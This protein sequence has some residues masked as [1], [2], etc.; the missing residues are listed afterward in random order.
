M[1]AVKT[2]SYFL[3]RNLLQQSSQTRREIYLA[4]TVALVRSLIIK[5][6]DIANQIHY[7][8]TERYPELFYGMDNKLNYRY[9]NHLAGNYLSTDTEMFIYSLDSK[10]TIRLDKD[11]NGHALTYRKLVDD[12]TYYKTLVAKYPTQER[13]I[14]GMISPIDIN[15]AIDADDSTILYHNP[16]LVE[17]QEYQLMDKIQNHISNM[18]YRWKISPYAN[19]D[20]YYLAVHEAVVILSV[21][22]KV[23]TYREDVLHT[24]EAHLFHVD[25][26]LISHGVGGELSYLNVDQ[27][28][29]LYRN[30]LYIKKHI[31]HSKTLKLMVKGLVESGKIPLAS[32]EITHKHEP[33]GDLVP[34]V[35]ATSNT[36]DIPSSTLKVKTIEEYHE[37]EIQYRQTNVDI[38]S[39]V[40]IGDALNAEHGWNNTKLFESALEAVVPLQDITYIEL[41]LAYLAYLSDMSEIT[42]TSTTDAG[43]MRI[44]DVVPYISI[45]TA[46]RRGETVTHVPTQIFVD[47]IVGDS[48]VTPARYPNVKITREVMEYINTRIFK[49]TQ[50]SDKKEFVSDM[51][52][53]H[54]A[55]IE[56]HQYVRSIEDAECRVEA[57]NLVD[58]LFTSADVD[59]V[60][61]GT[62]I[63]E[64]CLVRGLVD[65]RGLDIPQWDALLSDVI[66][67]TTDIILSNDLRGNQQATTIETLMSLSS[68]SIACT[69]SNSTL[70][71]VG[72]EYSS[73]RMIDVG[74]LSHGGIA[75]TPLNVNMTW[76]GQT[77]MEI[78]ESHYMALSNGAGT[79]LDLDP[80]YDTTRSIETYDFLSLST[81]GRYNRVST[82][83]NSSTEIPT[84]DDGWNIG[85]ADGMNQLDQALVTQIKSIY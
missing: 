42:Y 7:H 81:L 78:Y 27:K 62:E 65:P 10:S 85:N 73:S 53:L 43:I 11:I 38:P 24:V 34:V 75:G 46:L 57:I 21:I 23:M 17:P 28:S 37:L 1:N 2:N 8:D 9:Y 82:H 51:K 77:L 72:M 32:H 30:L 74:A 19:I 52:H 16:Q 13:L 47:G 59:L 6:E 80:E 60:G 70:Y 3:R 20:E 49:P 35:I 58:S 83:Y 41:T 66:V 14:K 67:N 31:G 4:N 18:H 22:P 63:T 84:F 71:G 64:W 48:L 25:E 79:Y 36:P 5:S 61:G 29:Y 44:Q 55:Y 26:Y 68:Y 45:L 50:Y 76:G 15:T 39:N 54:T 56:I 33:N 40:A 12:H 69:Y